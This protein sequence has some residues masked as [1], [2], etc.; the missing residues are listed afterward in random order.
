MGAGCGIRFLKVENFSQQSELSGR[1]ACVGL[2]KQFCVINPHT[3]YVIVDE[4]GKT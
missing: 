1:G 3:V 4:M 2:M